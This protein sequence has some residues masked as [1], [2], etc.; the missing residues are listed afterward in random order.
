MP[1]SHV[2]DTARWVAWY[3][4]METERQD[5][6]FR[7]PFARRLAGPEGEALV[8]EI[9]A[10][11][12]MAPALIVRTA[13]FD[14][15]ILDRVANHDIDLVLDLGAGLDAR[16][17]R[18]ALPPSLQWIDADHPA[19]LDYKTSLLRD[20]QPHCRYDAV[21]VD[22]TDTAAR[23]ALIARL[24]AAY[25]NALIVSEG[26]LIYLEPAAVADLARALHVPE[27]FRWWLADLA[28]PRL[29]K[30]IARSQGSSLLRAPFR[31][32]PGESGAFFRPF[33]WHEVLFRS[34]MEDARR[35]DRQMRLTW[36]WRILVQLRTP[37]VR[38][39][40][41]RMSG[42]VLLQRDQAVADA[43]P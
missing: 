8:H 3:R 7:D 21:P 40:F 32:A 28:N 43:T 16:P 4:A 19:I 18:L 33:G 1:I 23:N 35:L 30:I 9:P 25:R 26:L 39:E 14:E 6:I 12:R 41:R 17:W 5:A 11:L 2:S 24:G 36:L 42:V 38:E 22:L 29:L 27:S 15:L 34:A 13:V 20:E 10:G 37:A 31:F